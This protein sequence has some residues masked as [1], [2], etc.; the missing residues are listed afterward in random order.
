MQFRTIK[1][2]DLKDKKV[3]IR[4]DLDVPL[5]NGQVDD[6][7]RLVN[8]LPTIKYA[9]ENNAKQVIILGHLHRPGG[10]VVEDLRMDPV[11]KRLSELLEQPIKKL[12][13]CV[14]IEIPQDRIIMLENL[15]FHQ[16]ELDNYEFFAK[17]LAK[18]GD[19]YV[20]DSFAVSHR[21]HASLVGI[22]DHILS[23]AGLNLEKE[24]NMFAKATEDIEH[25]YIAIIGGKKIV[26]KIGVINNLVKKVDYL[27]LGGAMIFTFYKAKG[28]EIG[29]SLF[30]ADD[31][32]LAKLLLNNEKII[33]PTDV[34]VSKKADGTAES[35]TVSVDSMQK[36]D[37][38]LDIGPKT[39]SDYKETLKKARTVAWNGPMGLFEVEKFAKGSYELAK[40]LA[41]SDAT[42]IVGGGDTGAVLSEAGVADNI[43]HVSTGGGA[44]LTLLEGKPLPVITALINNKN[45]F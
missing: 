32:D 42:V 26:T 14:D 20:N 8:A 39:I 15:R 10:K 43:S 27:L 22:Q 12:N 6:D 31:V 7:A 30:E 9:L 21:T 40:F 17:K 25:P 18:L 2:V 44:S 13:D 1:E 29:K 28:M 35:R 16:G 5:E 11:A 37:I 38:G 19:V 23:C 34:V 36:D 24:I 45:H 3:L 41:K 33:L 4:C